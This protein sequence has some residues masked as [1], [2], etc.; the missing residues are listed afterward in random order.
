MATTPVDLY[1]NEIPGYPP[2]LNIYPESYTIK[3]PKDQVHPIEDVITSTT[4]D[5]EE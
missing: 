1:V 2:G 4:S 3:L 5:D